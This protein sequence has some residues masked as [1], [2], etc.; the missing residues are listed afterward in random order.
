MLQAGRNFSQIVLCPISA[1]HHFLETS[2]QVY[3]SWWVG[4][5]ASPTAA[6]VY[7]RSRQVKIGFATL[8]VAT[9]TVVIITTYITYGVSARA[10][11][12]S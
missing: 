7:T 11:W 2:G 9:K 4:V 12:K 6:E 10:N 5:L 8:E 1:E 3:P